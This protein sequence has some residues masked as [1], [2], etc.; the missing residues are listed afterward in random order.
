MQLSGIGDPD[1]LRSVGIT[2]LV[3]LRDVGEHLT[4]HPIL[5]MPWFAN[6]TKTED[7]ISRNATL[8]AEL[9]AQWNATGTGI[10][11]D[12]SPVQIMWARVTN[13]S[14]LFN[15]TVPDPSAGPTS[16]HLEI[17]TNVR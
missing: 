5:G 13:E 3:H 8:A 6:S 12:G 17:I 2:P 11:A 4:D 14:T 16:P 15:S 10:Y 9:Y 1:K 7:E